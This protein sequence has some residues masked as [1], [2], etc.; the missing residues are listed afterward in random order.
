MTIY[1]NLEDVPKKN[2]GAIYVDPAW[3]FKTYSDQT[4]KKG[5][6][7]AER[8]YRT[9]TEAEMLALPVKEI[10][11]KDCWLFMWCTWPHLPSGLRVMAHYGFRYS[12]DF[13]VWFKM[14]RSFSP[15]RAFLTLPTTRGVPHDIHI[16]TG[17]T[18]RKNSEFILLGRRGSPRTLAK[19]VLE[20]IFAPVREHSRKP[21]GVVDDIERFCNGPYIELNARTVREGWDQWG[22]Q[23]GMFMPPQ[24]PAI[25]VPEP[26]PVAVPL[27]DLEEHDDVEIP[28]FLKRLAN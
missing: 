5:S 26:E 3:R 23:A 21:D 15:T 2:Y 7:G 14:K 16:G 27:I 17:Y 1:A 8:H 12:S 19:D 25:F 11:A 9:M 22:D 10:A 4:G 24:P 18:S 20:P 13:K 28:A 6:R